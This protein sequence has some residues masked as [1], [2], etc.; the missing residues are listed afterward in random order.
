MRTERLCTCYC[1]GQVASLGFLEV[2]SLSFAARPHVIY[3]LIMFASW[4]RRVEFRTKVHYAV[5][6]RVGA[7]IDQIFIS[8]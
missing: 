2:I 1:G 4:R 3:C 6:Y 5:R 7:I 8:V